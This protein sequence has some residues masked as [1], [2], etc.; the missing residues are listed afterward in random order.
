VKG[1]A[2]GTIEWEADPDFGYQV[3]R[4]VPGIDEGDLDV[5]QPRL[6]YRATGRKDGYQAAVEQL[7]DDRAQFLSR[8]PSLSEEIVASVH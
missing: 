6:L 2:E 7:K 5:L 4:S 1:I 3:A 8:F